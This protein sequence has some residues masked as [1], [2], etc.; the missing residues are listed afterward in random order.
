MS[1]NT[2]LKAITTRYT[3]KY[4]NICERSREERIKSLQPGAALPAHG[5]LYGDEAREQFR[6][7]AD[8]CRVQ[9]ASIIENELKALNDKM[10]AAPSIEAVNTIQLLKMRSNVT[11]ADINSLMQRYGDNSQVYDTLIDIA[12]QHNLNEYK[13]E[14][15][16]LRVKANKLND[17]RSSIEKNLRLERA[18]R[19][20][21]SEGFISFLNAA[22]DD[23]LPEE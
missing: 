10:T 23:A 9:A 3:D 8:A 22:I 2:E 13:F 11:A 1:I 17:L 14:S 6:K 4:K 20:Y 16:P 15:N 18:E 7:E 21:A 5:K 19:G 12:G